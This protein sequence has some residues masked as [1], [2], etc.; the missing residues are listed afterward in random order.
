M[1]NLRLLSLKELIIERNL[2]LVKFSLLLGPFNFS[3]LHQKFFRMLWKEKNDSYIFYFSHK[4]LL[5]EFFLFISS[6]IK[7]VA[8]RYQKK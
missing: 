1:E 8:V 3:K 6:E 2:K 4:I 7:Q 5:I